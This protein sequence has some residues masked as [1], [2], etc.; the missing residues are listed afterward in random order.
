[1]LI[2]SSVPSSLTTLDEVETKKKEVEKELSVSS[3]RFTPILFHSIIPSNIRLNNAINQ[4][5]TTL[6]FS[7]PDKF[8]AVINAYKSRSSV[9]ENHSKNLDSFITELTEF[10]KKSLENTIRSLESQITYWSIRRNT[11]ENE[12]HENSIPVE[13]RLQALKDKLQASKEYLANIESKKDEILRKE[14]ARLD[15]DLRSIN[16]MISNFSANKS[17]TQGFVTQSKA[18]VEKLRTLQQELQDRLKELSDRALE[19]TAEAA[20]EV[21]QEAVQEATNAPQAGGGRKMNKTRIANRVKMLLK[22]HL[23]TRRRRA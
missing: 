6:G 15:T 13:D 22:K 12:Y 9:V 4:I 1:M 17:R 7:T 21:A 23:K 2:A 16:R 18:N 5:E 14:Q 10:E 8:D 11:S 19:L 20:V 3:S